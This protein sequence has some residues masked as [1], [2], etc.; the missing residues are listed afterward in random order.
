MCHCFLFTL[1]LWLGVT[2]TANTPNFF[3]RHATHFCMITLIRELQPG[4]YV[5]N[6]DSGHKDMELQRPQP[7]L[8]SWQRSSDDRNIILW[9][10]K[11][12]NRLWVT[13]SLFPSHT[14]PHFSFCLW[15]DELNFPRA[16]VDCQENFHPHL[17]DTCHTEKQSI[18]ACS[19]TANIPHCQVYLML[20]NANFWHFL[21]P[22]VEYAHYLLWCC[23]YRIFWLP[24]CLPAWLNQTFCWLCLFILL[25]SVHVLW[26][27]EDL[28][29]YKCLCSFVHLN[30]FHLVYRVWGWLT[31]YK[32]E[33]C[34][35]LVP[36]P[37]V[38]VPLSSVWFRRC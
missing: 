27:S 18:L 21:H 14:F 23:V 13:F 2:E 3:N 34:H 35:R 29:K 7:V 15:P 6:T 26:V 32:W 38:G 19:H 25:Y 9:Q 4:L 22:V 24:L 17:F 12:Y 31:V 5:I 36:W 37:G 1:G 11:L 20:M 28:F 10:S 30:C 16:V 33:V 8:Q